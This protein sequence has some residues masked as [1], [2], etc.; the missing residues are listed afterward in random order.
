MA[1]Y[2][3]Y[4]DTLKLLDNNNIQCGFV[5]SN[6]KKAIFR[7]IHLVNPKYWAAF[8]LMDQAYTELRVIQY[9]GDKCMSDD[10]D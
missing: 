6:R 4:G 8:I 5:M 3:F 1:I 7:L 2:R 10:S 9:N